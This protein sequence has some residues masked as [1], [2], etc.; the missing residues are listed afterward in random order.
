MVRMKAS[1]WGME[2]ATSKEQLLELVHWSDFLLLEWV[3][4]WTVMT[5]VSRM[6]PR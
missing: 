5:M 3:H 6:E 4:W 1:N 2:M